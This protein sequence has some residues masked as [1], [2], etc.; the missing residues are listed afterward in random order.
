[1]LALL[2]T[3]NQQNNDSN[4]RHTALLFLLMLLSKTQVIQP[5]FVTG[6]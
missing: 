6:M 4:W 3:Q 1:M 2:F 5:L